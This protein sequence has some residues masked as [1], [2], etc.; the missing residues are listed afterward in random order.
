MTFAAYLIITC[1]W[2]FQ[3]NIEPSFSSHN[4]VNLTLA[5]GAT[6][7]LWHLKHFIL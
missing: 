3:Y 7:I 4:L 5:G 2:L 1:T 6:F